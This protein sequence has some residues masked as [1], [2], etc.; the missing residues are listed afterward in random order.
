[1][2][3]LIYHPVKNLIAKLY[4]RFL[5]KFAGIKMIGVT[6]SAGKTTTKEMI[7][8]IVKLAA[9]TVWSGANIDPIYNIPAT[10]LR[11]TPKTKYLVLEMGVEHPGEMDFYLSFVKPDI[12]VITNIFP[13]HTEFLGDIDGV[14]KEKGK[15]VLSLIESG[16]A[17]L[18][19]DDK[20]LRNLA[21][22]LKAKV[23][24]FDGK[25]NLLV[26]NS[27][28]AAKVAD[29]LGIDGK[30]IKKGLESYAK[31][32][33][34]LEIVK[35]KSGATILD[36]SYNSNPLAAIATLK[37]FNNVVK[38]Q[39]IAKAEKIAVL[40]DMLEL[41]SFEEKGHRALGVEVAKSGFKAVIGVGKA[42]KFMLD[43]VRKGSGKTE[44]F[45]VENWQEALRLVRHLS[46]KGS[47]VLVKG[48]RSIGLDKLVEEL[49]L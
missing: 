28:A 43:E 19:K 45:R 10:I 49:I 2:K 39:K 16:T 13:A 35:S 22:A 25:G 8:S 4:M 18:N 24:W 27:A 42:S 31:P 20:K 29:V 5:R 33:H 36:D 37:Y 38:N 47:Y 11:C 12:G 48:S 3:K 14:L 44:T 21:K 6:G 7:A 26:Q 30:L 40:G 1:M 34:R 32:E 41:G 9:P 23:V 17:V 46:L 15:L